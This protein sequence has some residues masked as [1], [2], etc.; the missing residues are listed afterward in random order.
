M[1]IKFNPITNINAKRPP[2]SV[3]VNDQKTQ[4]EPEALREELTQTKMRLNAIVQEK[5][6]LTSK[7]RALEQQ[8]TQLEKQYQAT[9]QTNV[10]S[11]NFP[12]LDIL[13]NEGGLIFILPVFQSIEFN[14]MNRSIGTNMEDNTL[15]KMKTVIKSQERK[16][17]EQEAELANLKRNIRYTKLV[18]YEVELK[19]YFHE[20]LRLRRLLEHEEAGTQI[21]NE[22]ASELLKYDEAIEELNQKVVEYKETIQTLNGELEKNQG[23]VATL[24]EE[25]DAL[26]P[27]YQELLDQ[28]D[29]KVEEQQRAEAGLRESHE[30]QGSL[31]AEIQDLRGRLDDAMGQ[32]SDCRGDL[33]NAVNAWNETE[34]MRK[35]MQQALD[36]ANGDLD[37]LS[38]SQKQFDKRYEDLC[39]E[40]ATLESTLERNK[41]QERLLMEELDQCQ[42]AF[43]RC[44]KLNAALNRE[45]N[46]YRQKL[47][48]LEAAA[49]AAGGTVLGGVVPHGLPMSPEPANTYSR[50]SVATGRP[51][52]VLG[53]QIRETN[54]M[55][56]IESTT[57]S[58][59]TASERGSVHRHGAENDGT[60]QRMPGRITAEPSWVDET[61]SV[62]AERRE[63][64]L[65][66]PET[67][68]MEAA[69][70]PRVHTEETVQQTRTDDEDYGGPPGA[71]T[72]RTD[73][74]SELDQM[75]PLL[76][77][78]N[79][80][81]MSEAPMSPPP[82]HVPYTPQSSTQSIPATPVMG[83][84]ARID[85]RTVPMDQADAGGLT[86]PPQEQPHNQH[87]NSSL[88]NT[89]KETSGSDPEK[90]SYESLQMKGSRESGSMHHLVQQQQQRALG[91]GGG[92]VSQAPQSGPTPENTAINEH[93][94]TPES[95]TPS[96]AGRGS[97]PTLA[98]GGSFSTVDDGT[99]KAKPTSTLDT[100]LPPINQT[101][102]SSAPLTPLL[103]LAG[104]TPLANRR[105]SFSTLS[106]HS[107]PSLP[108]LS[109]NPELFSRS[110]SQ[111]SSSAPKNSPGSSTDP[112][113]ASEVKLPPATTTS[114]GNNNG[115][116]SRTFNQPVSINGANA[117]QGPIPPGGGGFKP[118]KRSG[119]A[120][121]SS[122]V[123]SLPH[124]SGH[125]QGSTSGSES[126]FV[127]G[128]EIQA[129]TSTASQSRTQSQFSSPTIDT[130]DVKQAQPPKYPPPP[131]AAESVVQSASGQ[132]LPAVRV[133]PSNS[134]NSHVTTVA[135]QQ[136][137]QH[138]KQ[139]KQP[140]AERRQS[141]TSLAGPQTT[142]AL[143]PPPLKASS[144]SFSATE[145][146]SDTPSSPSGTFESS[147]STWTSTA[148]DMIQ[149]SPSI[150]EA[151]PSRTV[152]NPPASSSNAEPT[153]PTVTSRASRSSGTTRTSS[154]SQSVTSLHTT[155]TTT[156]TT[157]AA[158][159]ATRV[160]GTAVTGGKGPIP[161]VSPSMS[162]STDMDGLSSSENEF[163]TPKTASPS[164][165][166][167]AASAS[168]A[169]TERKVD[170]PAQ[171][172][173]ASG[174]PTSV[175]QGGFL[176]EQMGKKP[177]SSSNSSPDP[178]PAGNINNK[179]QATGQP[180]ADVTLTK[181]D[182][183]KALKSHSSF[184]TRSALSGSQSFTDSITSSS[185]FTSESRK[186]P[187]QKPPS[188]KGKIATENQSM[189]AVTKPLKQIS[190]ES[191]GTGSKW[192]VSDLS[193][194]ESSSS[195]EETNDGASQKR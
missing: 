106:S 65:R 43:D 53:D 54:S 109:P 8:N 19:A 171:G 51:S 178:V 91:S 61:E 45:N 60:D 30:Q 160:A 177:E 130:V 133:T 158:A 44:N 125:P 190:S 148:T 49:A 112:N 172:A 33:Q 181:G 162:E 63:P 31:H 52:S 13:T 76:R 169:Q 156:T 2:K 20:T 135:G 26:K 101:A 103:D 187:N 111:T 73:S 35:E 88:L 46:H 78:S 104:Q 164:S 189:A 118:P 37:S 149:S 114:S 146:A 107:S 155:T 90:T 56:T 182:E 99:G 25:L 94:S 110:G 38:Q 121:F 24:Q 180:Q 175:E 186:G 70:M 126:P 9:L 69:H 47:R 12:L 84:A 36:H 96:A 42:K 10:R 152:S 3:H 150:S 124:I 142:S 85:D 174:P 1:A 165:Q 168:T 66:T 151:T 185:I 39:Q 154:R 157:A 191:E 138:S 67:V 173:H 115:Q 145:G 82:Q 166:Y 58:P 184:G 64:G 122:S 17:K 71:Q 29:A 14:N 188:I 147:N 16:M 86:S 137:Q 41:K 27:K 50:E 87:S 195:G 123:V 11:Y 153:D 193:L 89:N 23:L 80:N 159:A 28:Y 120:T 140:P 119:S 128:T 131:N 93:K 59:T 161:P 127:S 18:E 117:N 5:K 136:Q 83:E 97:A 68:T 7:V 113:P 194:S 179:P 134:G 48:A 98:S 192:S 129:P 4:K 95:Q 74:G 32:L 15:V 72:R 55:V 75:S 141:E 34:N 183:N 170:M 163:H 143:R 108:S 144:S 116:A 105:M 77:R 167:I 40:K 92:S 79:T 176:A 132:T 21:I 57:A 6:V 100:P 102:I 22:Q 62:A 81:E 139:V